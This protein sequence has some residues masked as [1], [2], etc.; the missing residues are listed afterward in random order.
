MIRRN[1]KKT[2]TDSK[3][4][5]PNLFQNQKGNVGKRNGLGHWDWPIYTTTHK[6]G[7]KG[8]LFNT[9]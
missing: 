9:L 3:I 2:E 8:N 4:S 7:N 6:I 5:K 1:L